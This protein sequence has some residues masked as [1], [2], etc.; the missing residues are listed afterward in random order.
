MLDHVIHLRAS[1]PVQQLDEIFQLK[2]VK[3]SAFAES[4]CAEVLI[5]SVVSMLAETRL[6][7][8]KNVASQSL[9]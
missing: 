6:D 8:I 5:V 2:P 4:S 3:C 9:E 1:T 7:V